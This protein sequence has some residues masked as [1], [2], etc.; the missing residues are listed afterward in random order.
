MKIFSLLSRQTPLNL[1]C[2]HIFLPLFSFFHSRASAS[3]TRNNIQ[4]FGR[5]FTIDNRFL[6]SEKEYFFSAGIFC[7]GCVLNI[8]LVMKHH[9]YL[10][11]FVSSCYKIYWNFKKI[12]WW[13]FKNKCVEIW[14]LDR[15]IFYMEK[16]LNQLVEQL[17]F[18][19]I[20]LSCII[21]HIKL[22]A[23]G[24]KTLC[25]RDFCIFPLILTSFLYHFL[26]CFLKKW[27]WCWCL[28][29]KNNLINVSALSP[30][31]TTAVLV[32]WTLLFSN[33]KKSSSWTLNQ[34]EYQS[35]HRYGGLSI[36]E[37]LTGP[38]NLLFNLYSDAEKRELREREREKP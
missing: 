31:D 11:I 23:N 38:I 5:M 34:I 21:F 17:V 36:V 9:L 13:R 22:N 29:K 6:H 14:K 15:I 27:W 28:E 20:C 25:I 24:T 3:Y 2:P 37:Y 10:Y 19:S 8:I 26:G 1:K 33:Q 4:R 16:S 30:T 12:F 35:T 32:L 7:R 18:D